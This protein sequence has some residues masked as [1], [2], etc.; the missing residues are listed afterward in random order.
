MSGE[1]QERLPRNSEEERRFRPVPRISS[2]GQHLD[3]GDAEQDPPL[4]PTR[5][6]PGMA[7][8]STVGT[9]LT[10]APSDENADPL[11]WT[12]VDSSGCSWAGVTTVPEQNVHPDA[13]GYESPESGDIDDASLIVDTSHLSHLLNAPVHPSARP[14]P[15]PPSH[16]LSCGIPP[17]AAPVAKTLGPRRASSKPP[18]KCAAMA[19][20]ILQRDGNR[21]PSSLDRP[22]HT[23]RRRNQRD[24]IE[25]SHSRE[26]TPP[27]RGD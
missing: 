27:D 9:A 26:S 22:P 8:S 5:F 23:G 16:D 20:P 25:T 14:A 19:N 15:M 24:M 18:G 4:A 11:G 6:A 10:L 12:T 1:D 3:A 17:P 2:G 21:L 7:R 13:V